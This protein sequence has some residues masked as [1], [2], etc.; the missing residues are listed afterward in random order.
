MEI[1]F[2]VENHRFEG[3]E[4]NQW[5]P[6]TDGVTNE[7]ATSL[8]V[9]TK[10]DRYRIEVSLTCNLRC[11]YC[12]VHMNNVS[13]QNTVM[14]MD[15]A[16]HI[17]NQFNQEV[18]ENGSIFLMGGEPLINVDVVKYFVENIRGTSIIFTNAFSLTE[19][20]I[21]F[22]YNHGTYILTSLDGYSL[23]QN[24]KRFWPNVQKNYD[25]VTENIRKAINYGCKVGVSCLLHKGNITEAVNIAR[26]FTDNLHA[27]SM[28]FAYP[29]STVEHSE[30]SD[31][32]FSM[33]T[34]ELKQLFLF[35]KEKR[36]YI[37]QIGKI[38]GSLVYNSPS[39]IG[40]KSGTTQRT[41]YPDGSETICTKIDTL[42]SFDINQ[43]CKDLPYVKKECADCIAKYLCC[44]ECPWD[45]AVANISG[46]QHHRICEYRKHLISFIISDI[47]S[48][49]SKANSV[50]EA[51]NIFKLLYVPMTNNYNDEE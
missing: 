2:N 20:L 31:F 40:C 5:L 21:E 33:Y 43:Y 9:P 13:Q 17:V 29:H 24:E 50:E 8:N 19:E 45:Y 15:T 51:K 41:F 48:E 38:L 22:F 36:V 23:E 42:N 35:A 3:F 25:K 10:I 16:K 14:S 28:S 37:D 49:L 30:E 39:L 11:K 26:F 47:C 18:G 32:D 46:R 1:Q 6:I 7:L 27:R 4:N 12:V 34:E 44:G